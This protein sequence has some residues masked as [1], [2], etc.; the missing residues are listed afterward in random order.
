MALKWRRSERLVQGRSCIGMGWKLSIERRKTLTRLKSRG[1]GGPILGS[2]RSRRHISEQRGDRWRPTGLASMS[3]ATQHNLINNSARKLTSE[4]GSSSTSV[5]E[6]A[7]SIRSSQ[8]LPCA[9]AAVWG[10][11]ERALR[12]PRLGRRPNSFDLGRSCLGFRADCVMD[13]LRGRESLSLRWIGG[14]VEE[15]PGGEWLRIEGR[16]PRGRGEENGGRASCLKWSR[17]DGSS[18]DERIRP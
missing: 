16:S 5:A 8:R 18:I 11:A 12:S 10:S 13:D 7:A 4:Y 17:S 3:V 2:R 15:R 9:H 6:V 1:E 14:K